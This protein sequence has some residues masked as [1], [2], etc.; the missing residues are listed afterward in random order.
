VAA[1]V[2]YRAVVVI[3]QRINNYE[4]RA[5]LGEG[6]MAA[7]YLAEHPFIGRQV[8]VKLLHPSVTKAPDVVARFLNEAKAAN[9][10]GHPNIIDILDVGMLPD[11]MPYLIMELLKGESLAGRLER[12]RSLPVAAAL[13][14]AI[15]AASA[16]GAAHAAGIVHRDLKPANLFLTADLDKP[17]RDRVKVLDF[18]IAK[19]AGTVTGNQTKTTTGAILGTPAYMSPEQSLGRSTAIDRRTDIYSL[20]VILHHALAGELPF[21]AEGFGEMM[22]L[23]ITAPP[24]PL[25]TRNPQIS[26]ELEALVLRALAK[27]PEAR[28]QSMAEIE[29]AL[30]AE[31]V[32]L[33]GTQAAGDGEAA[34]RVVSQALLRT[35]QL[36]D[37]VKRAQK[38]SAGPARGDIGTTFSSTA[39]QLSSSSSI[40]SEAPARSARIPWPVGAGLVVVA[41]GVIIVVATGRWSSPA[42]PHASSAPPPAVIAPPPPRAPEPAP[43][44]AAATGIAEPAAAV[45]PPP[46][47]K[48]EQARPAPRPPRAK[49]QASSRGASPT[50]TA[51][52]ATVPSPDAPPANAAA[53]S[54]LVPP[55]PAR[56]SPAAPAPAKKMRKW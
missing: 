22:M 9:A 7:V 24:P 48:A 1:S 16:V 11:G 50:R 12:D 30:K 8:A 4:I 51:R 20:G 2:T 44:P 25:R 35:I 43:P 31:V 3:G 18:G 27:R 10:I 28:F 52:T 26:A 14:V 36:P 47:E 23:H 54:I 29:A 46:T 32:R 15:Q 34:A 38:P 13:D 45:T 5:L 19:L 53:P 40:T 41:I 6:G 55:S 56:G 37:T 33:E 39:S 17:A 21:M 42:A 49:T